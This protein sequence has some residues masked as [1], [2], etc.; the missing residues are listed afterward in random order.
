M[1]KNPRP[2]LRIAFTDDGRAALLCAKC[3]V[4]DSFRH[5]PFGNRAQGHNQ[6]KEP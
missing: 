6:H 2:I 1:M 5:G 4:I 3:R